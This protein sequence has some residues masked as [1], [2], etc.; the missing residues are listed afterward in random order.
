[1]KVILTDITA[2]LKMITEDITV[3]IVIPAIT[4]IVVL[5]IVHEIVLADAMKDV[6]AVALTTVK[7]VI[8]ADD[9]NLFVPNMPLY[10]FFILQ[11]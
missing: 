4:A 1:M 2:T 7:I 8:P 9:N 3:V 10:L 5:E 6:I 11:C